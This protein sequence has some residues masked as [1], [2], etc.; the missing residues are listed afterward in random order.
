MIFNKTLGK[1]IEIL[2]TCFPKYYKPKY[3]KLFNGREVL[4]NAMY[5]GYI[6][7]ARHLRIAEKTHRKIFSLEQLVLVWCMILRDQAN[8]AFI[9]FE[10]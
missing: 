5:M 2:I 6:Y 1:F 7:M 10:K 8:Y 4:T 3:S 9:L